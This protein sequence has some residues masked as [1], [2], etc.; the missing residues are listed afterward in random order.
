MAKKTGLVVAGIA[1]LLALL[2]AGGAEAKEGE[3]KKRGRRPSGTR[4][5]PR[6]PR[7][8]SGGAKS[9]GATDEDIGRIDILNLEGADLYLDPECNFAV[10]GA[11]FFPTPAPSPVQRLRLGP[12]DVRMEGDQPFQMDAD[13][14]CSPMRL[15]GRRPDF[16]IED[17][18][19]WWTISG[20][21]TFS[22]IIGTCSKVDG[23]LKG[24]CFK[25]PYFCTV[26]DVIDSLILDGVT[27][28][29]LITDAIVSEVSPLCFDAD[30]DFWGDE[31]YNWYDNFLGRVVDYVELAVMDFEQL[32]AMGV[33][34]EP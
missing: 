4:P 24:P 23:T 17:E 21:S 9:F 28:P 18:S 7:T 10:E 31:F 8:T 16:N 2:F 3:T 27:D 30:P 22:Q 26:L 6:P 20:R 1:G 34:I 33:V 14:E 15:V 32:E 12:A 25:A 13:K 5:P 19:T 11:R 29:K